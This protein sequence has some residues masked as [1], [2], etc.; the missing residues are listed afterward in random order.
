MLKP[1]ILSAGQVSTFGRL[2]LFYLDYIKHAFEIGSVYFKV[3][4][5]IKAAAVRKPRPG[6]KKNFARLQLF[7]PSLPLLKELKPHKR[8]ILYCVFVNF[9]ELEEFG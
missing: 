5:S 7:P 2:M 3:F 4:T 9:T 6:R 8:L 1:K